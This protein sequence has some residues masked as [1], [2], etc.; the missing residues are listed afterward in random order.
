M[1]TVPK[2]PTSD[3]HFI[4]GEIVGVEY[5]PL[6]FHTD[7]RGWLVELFRSD[8]LAE[9]LLPQMAYLS[10]TSPG[11]VRGP[12]EHVEQT[13]FFAFVGPGNF[14]LKLWDAR[15]DSPTYLHMDTTIVGESNPQAVIVPPGVVHAYKKISSY[16]GWVFNA[17]NQLYAGYGKQEL[18]DEIR[19]EDW[20]S[21]FLIQPRP[22]IDPKPLRKAA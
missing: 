8:E 14:M 5:R 22:C 16:A 3:M 17:P 6:R 21:P 9:K 19:H 12:H 18:V 11:V 2:F 20:A 1:I 13:D 10:Q 15:R 4:E 7:Q